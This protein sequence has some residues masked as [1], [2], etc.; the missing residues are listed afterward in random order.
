MQT[1]GM[2]A[3]PGVS[4]GFGTILSNEFVPLGRTAKPYPEMTA[5]ERKA[6]ASIN[7][8]SGRLPVNRIKHK[9]ATL[10]KLLAT[11]KMACARSGAIGLW[12]VS[13]IW[14]INGPI[15]VVPQNSAIINS[16]VTMKNGLSVCFRLNSRNFSIND[17]AGWEQML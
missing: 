15:P 11:L 6:A 7:K 4:S 2:Y 12:Y 14:A 8:Y 5:D 9:N 1:N 3:S 16:M 13:K 10:A 17:G